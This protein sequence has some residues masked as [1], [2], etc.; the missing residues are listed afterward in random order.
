MANV[1]KVFKYSATGVLSFHSNIPAE[2]PDDTIRG[3]VGVGRFL[4]KH[5]TG[6]REL[7]FDPKFEIEI[8][9]R[10]NETLMALN[11]D[12]MERN[13]S[14]AQHV[15]TLQAQLSKTTVELEDSQTRIL[16]MEASART[17]DSQ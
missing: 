2:L 15:Q 14:L 4:L 5:P 8:E 11:A 13:E 3:I 10:K 9:G 1:R 17:T 6:D 16:N 12:L 7:T